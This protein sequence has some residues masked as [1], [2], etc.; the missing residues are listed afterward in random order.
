MTEVDATASARPP[1]PA[2]LE[3]E[4]LV[5]TL[6]AEQLGR[7]K[8]ASEEDFFASGG[9]S[10]AA[11]KVVVALRRAL[12]RDVPITFLHEHRTASAVAAALD[13]LPAPPADTGD[14][15]A[16]SA[17]TELRD[18]PLTA[19][20]HAIWQAM[21]LTPQV[22]VYNIYV[23]ADLAGPVREAGLRDAAVIAAS[24]HAGAATRLVSGP[25]PRQRIVELTAGSAVDFWLAPTT[26]STGGAALREWLIGLAAEPIDVANGPAVRL[27]LAR[28]GHHHHVLILVL[29]HLFFDAASARSFIGT[30]AAAYRGEFDSAT[31]PPLGL[32]SGYGVTPTTADEHVAPVRPLWFQHHDLDPLDVRGGYLQAWFDQPDMRTIRDAVAACRTTL[33]CLVIAGLAVVVDRVGDHEPVT[34]TLPVSDRYVT[35]PG[36]AVAQGLTVRL[37]HIRVEVSPQDTLRSL[38]ST[39]AS[40]IAEVSRSGRRV[41]PTP[42]T[43]ALGAQEDL[44]TDLWLPGVTVSERF[45]H[46]GTSKFALSLLLFDDPMRLDA[47]YL[48]QACDAADAKRFLGLVARTVVSLATEPD[49]PIRELGL[50]AGPEGA[51]TSRAAVLRGARTR[52]DREQCIHGQFR[53]AATRRPDH[54]AVV[55]GDRTVTYQQL[56]GAADRVAA[57]VADRVR[58]HSAGVAVLAP[59][60]P[61][62]IAAALGVLAAGHYYVLLDHRQP[63][64]R[65]RTVVERSGVQLVLA[66][67]PVDAGELGAPAVTDLADLTGLAGT[68]AHG[69]AAGGKLPTAAGTGQPESIRWCEVDPS[70]PACVFFSSGSTGTPKGVLSTH[71]AAM[72]TFQGQ[73]FGRFGPDTRML[74]VSA[75]SWDAFSL[76]TWGPLLNGGTCVLYDA[77]D[78]EIE[79]IARVIRDHRV[80]T[81]FFTTSL[82]NAMVDYAPRA[83]DD[84]D[85]V[86]FGGEPA[87]EA[88]LRRY[89]ERAPC[90]HE[91]LSNAYGPVEATVFVTLYRVPSNP[92]ELASSLPVGTPIAN[93]DVY[94]LDRYG[95]PLPIGVPGELCVSGDGLALGYRGDPAGT[96]DLF[97]PDPW[98]DPG[99]RL[100]RTGDLALIDDTGMIRLRGRIDR[101]IKASGQRVDLVEVE[102]AVAAL[103]EGA[104]AA[105]AVPAATGTNEVVVFVAPTSS[106]ARV[107]ADSIRYALARKLPAYLVPAQIRPV[108]RIPLTSTGKVD[109][110]GLR[111]LLG[112]PHRKDGP[113]MTEHDPQATALILQVVKAVLEEQLGRPIRDDQGFLAAGGASLAAAR[114][115]AGLSHL[116]GVG[117]SPRDIL[118]A[119]DPAALVE[120]VQQRADN[121]TNFTRRL[122]AAV[123][124]VSIPPDLRTDIAQVS[125]AAGAA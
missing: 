56:T 33:F 9:H 49:L 1:L 17:T 44:L 123:H 34:V 54:A 79:G 21:Q 100:Y 104:V 43:V 80:N 103:V 65:L 59:R 36:Q 121:Q 53:H 29:P 31:G 35:T 57:V 72:R 109:A 28:I 8:L 32:P 124:F 45:I 110:E 84:L 39:V 60:S 117:V 101:Q 14:R 15:V 120:T 102:A 86:L 41:Q 3:R 74:T 50:D 63:T 61:E 83:L 82:F 93:T 30:L 116:L 2:A 4:R 37:D 5:T 6:M 98:G 73:R 94:I 112:A 118:Q 10:L 23:A 12:A 88:H 22:G 91:H 42:P 66:V 71:R 75:V 115:A 27:G 69:V 122:R 58:G 78:V 107:D 76:E 13:R 16:G 52:Y 26:A 99:T 125:G 62:L 51:P 47:E 38:V 40:R 108:E 77:V 105:I 24:H 19:A 18:A 70:A 55:V 87:S 92:R 67:S 106:V 119:T 7:D 113:D 89:L 11:T 68:T 85:E 96:A 81:A 48:T 46:N 20:Q 111:A 25:Q 97:R 95:H 90:V 64:A 114:A